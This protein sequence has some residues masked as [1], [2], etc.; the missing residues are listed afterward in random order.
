MH[1]LQGGKRRKGFLDEEFSKAPSADF[2]DK[3]NARLEQ[4]FGSQGTPQA[5][6]QPELRP[7]PPR[8]SSEDK[9]LPPV[10]P[11]DTA[12]PSNEDL[13]PLESPK[14]A[15]LTKSPPYALSSAVILLTNP[16]LDLTIV[17]CLLLP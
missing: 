14:P 2:M 1:R 16:V 15:F 11:K 12:G 6:A 17:S 13:A 10:P 3:V 5:A 8:L 4:A 9:E 7:S